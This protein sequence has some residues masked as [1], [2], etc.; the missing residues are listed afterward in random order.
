MDANSKCMFNGILPNCKCRG[1]VDKVLTEKK[2]EAILQ[3]S[4]LRK[5]GFFV[6]SDQYESLF[7]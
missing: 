3:S 7:Q 6:N 2:Q 5:D 1:K 4:E